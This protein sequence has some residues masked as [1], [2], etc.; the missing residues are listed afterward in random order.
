MT[1]RRLLTLAPV[2]M[3]ALLIL[4]PVLAHAGGSAGACCTGLACSF[5]TA[6]TCTSLGGDYHGDGTTCTPGLCAP[7]PLNHFQCYDVARTKFEPVPLDLEDDFGASTA[8]VRRAKMLCAP[9][10][11][12]DEDP[13]APDDPD[14]LVGYEIRRDGRFQGVLDEVVEDQ[15]GTLVLDIRRPERILVPSAKQADPNDV[16]TPLDPPVVDHY[17][18][19]SVRGDRRRVAGV[20]LE[21]QFGTGSA[22]VKKPSRLCLPVN[23]NG[24][25]I[26]DGAA[27]LMCY[28]IKPGPR[29]NTTVQVNNQFGDDELRVKRARELCIPETLPCLCIS[30]W[31][32]GSAVPP[33]SQVVGLGCDAQAT[34]GPGVAAAVPQLAEP[35]YR[36]VAGFTQQTGPENFFCQSI[37]LTV[38][39]TFETLLIEVSDPS[40]EVARCASP[41]VAA[42]CVFP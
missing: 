26:V 42:G 39:S 22:D 15:F 36:Y 40:L 14:H 31:E 12:N 28:A 11:K 16:V 41:L 20:T 18:C 25:G 10:N 7:P 5:E 21:D 4:S 9:V 37:D 1:V 32:S 2:V 17:Q 8:T 23:K 27:R 6:V 33:L 30:T 3:L 35:N 13:T 34:V 38:E 24:E 19:Y 29:V